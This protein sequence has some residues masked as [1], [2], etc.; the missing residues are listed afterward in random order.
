MEF[1][2]SIGVSY[3]NPHTFLL[4]E[5][6]LFLDFQPIADFKRQSD[7]KGLLNPGKIGSKY[8]IPQETV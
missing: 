8:F 5:S 1:C 4:E 3:L 2:D 7:P 6:G